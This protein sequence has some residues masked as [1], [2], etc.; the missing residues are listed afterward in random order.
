MNPSPVWSTTRFEIDL[1][2]PRLMGIVNL[3]PDSFSDGGRHDSASAGAAHCERLL[4]EGAD[5]LDLGAES[6]RPGAASVDATSE[7]QR[8]EPVLRAALGLGVPVSVDT[9]KAEVMARALDLG[10]DI[11][12]DVEALRGPQALPTVA[13]HPRCGICLMHMPGDPS[14][15]QRSPAYDDVVREVGA[16][17]AQRLHACTAAGI[18]AERVVLDPG[19]GF[20]KTPEHNLALLGR[21]SELMALGRPL[22]AAWSRKSTLGVITG[23][24]VGERLAASLAAALAAVSRG[25]AVVRVHDVAAT[26]DALQ[27]WD[28]VRIAAGDNPGPAAIQG[29][30]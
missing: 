26:R 24:P 19:V 7:W 11:I 28:A 29:G 27:V 22:L 14:T 3:T 2:R 4:A 17:L 21:Q 23:R 16:F 1:S 25:A 15:M 5:I 20:G 18:R 30:R 6:T 10:A 12:N 8:L 13:R 9:R